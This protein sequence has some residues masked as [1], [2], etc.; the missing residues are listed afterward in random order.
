MADFIFLKTEYSEWLQRHGLARLKPMLEWTGDVLVGEH[1]QRRVWRTE[2]DGGTY[3]LRLERRIPLREILSDLLRFRR[4]TS[5]AMKAVQ[6]ARWFEQNGVATAD[7]RCLIERRFL[8]LPIRAGLVQCSV[9]GEDLY[10]V[11]RRFGRPHQRKTNP[12]HRQRLLAGL[13][14]LLSKIHHGRGGGVLWPD[15]AAKHI[16]A[17][18]DPVNPEGP[19]RFTLIDVER[20]GGRPSP[21]QRQKQMDK[22]LQSLRGLLSPTDLVRLAR[23]YLGTGTIPPPS[24]RRKLWTK[25]FPAGPRWLDRA[26]AEMPAL[27]A[28]PDD[29]P[30]AEEELFERVGFALVVNMRFKPA[31]E[32]LGLLEEGR[33]FEFQHGSELYKPGLGRR[34]RMRFE[35]M[36]NG[37][38]T[39]LYLKR[40]RH[41]RLRDQLDRILCGTVR[42]SR[43]WHERY[44]IKQIGRHRIPGPVVVAYA[45][46]MSAGYERTG[47]LVTEG[48]VGQ[49]LEKFLPKH[50]RRGPNGHNLFRRREWI[51]GLAR[52]IGRFHRAGFIH[53]DLYLSHIFVRLK[54]NGDPIF[55]LIDLARAFRPIWRKTRWVVKDLA[56]LN[57]ST[58][59]AIISAADRMRF[60]KLYLGVN[61]LG[62]EEKKLARRIIRKT[63]RIAGHQ[64][65]HGVPTLE[66]KL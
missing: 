8:G 4:P 66:R 62:K 38:P 47:V 20:A 52:L 61:R 64:A 48:I 10:Q 29:Q 51:C 26:K 43:C 31:L 60:F 21:S 45:E 3:Y 13:G 12:R 25:F 14:E 22:F 1:D 30:L 35:T 46:K 55:C 54:T 11:L 23:G 33:I 19:W 16:F 58:P 65:R 7:W 40:V 49:S 2:L 5:R 28:F 9:P 42:H 6:G 44:M 41:P 57:F 53:R 59:R 39:W 50:F 34:I 56:G 15:L 37:R 24:V 63:R 18:P 32:N 17:A 27:R 36:L